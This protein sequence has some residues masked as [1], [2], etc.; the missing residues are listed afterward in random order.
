MIRLPSAAVVT[1]VWWLAS[2]AAQT[3]P[4]TAVRCQQP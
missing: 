2:A 3:V 1:L 4:T